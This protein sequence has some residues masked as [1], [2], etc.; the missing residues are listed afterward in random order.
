MITVI[1]A[2]QK[3]D[4]RGKG[5]VIHVG[6]PSVLGNPFKEGRDGTRLEVIEKFRALLRDEYRTGGPRMDEVN[7]LVDRHLRG[8][9]LLLMCHCAPLPC[10]GHVIKSAIERIAAQRVSQ[11]KANSKAVRVG[12]AGSR[13]LGGEDINIEL[14][15]SIFGEF[16]PGSIAVVGDSIGFDAAIIDTCLATGRAL[17]IHSIMD[18]SGQG[19][20]RGTAMDSVFKAERAGNK[21]VWH[22]EPDSED[23]LVARLATR[24]IMAVHR[25][26]RLIAVFGHN[27]H[28]SKGTKLA[29]ETA[30][31]K[32]LPVVAYSRLSPPN[33]DEWGGYWIKTGTVGSDWGRYVWHPHHEVWAGSNKPLDLVQ[34]VGGVVQGVENTDPCWRPIT[35]SEILGGGDYP[36]PRGLLNFAE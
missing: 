28:G 23:S 18:K 2:K 34:P 22:G 26:D 21:V 9:N 3:N 31:K 10:H 24:T 15:C 30:A 11:G 27:P 1:N 4:W 7:K 35:V 20:W 25:C 5:T 33:L 8:E 6:R 17:E 16:P 32:R 29:C 13:N 12:F 14:K 36:G 19:G